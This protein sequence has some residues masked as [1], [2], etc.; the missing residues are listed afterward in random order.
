MNGKI[1]TKLEYEKVLD[2]L[3]G[4][5]ATSLGKAWVKKLAPSTNM[6]EVK[7]R[8]Q[9]TD[10]AANVLRLKGAMPFGGIRD[11]LAPLR[12]AEIGGMLNP[13]ELLDIANTMSGARRLQRFILQVHGDYTIPLLAELCKLLTEHRSV[14][15][16]IRF[17]IDEN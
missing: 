3:L 5:A 11:V 10:E 12:R 7:L 4:H 8:L 17:C 6:A 1:L 16:A 13:A 2:M 14:E 9:A 15:E